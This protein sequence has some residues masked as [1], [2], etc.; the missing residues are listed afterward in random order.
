MNGV[1]KYSD[2]GLLRFRPGERTGPAVGEDGSD[3]GGAARKGVP[4]ALPGKIGDMVVWRRDHLSEQS[5]DQNGQWV[6]GLV[7]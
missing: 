3:G 6:Q 5:V 7:R 4:A 2:T 1:F